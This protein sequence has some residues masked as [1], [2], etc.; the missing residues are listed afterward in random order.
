MFLISHLFGPFIGNT[1]PLAF[2]IVDPHP[3]YPITV[4][5]ISITAFWLYP[6][7]LRFWGH[8]TAL[9]FISIQ[10]LM[11][12]ILW[13]CFFYGGV[14]SPTVPWILTIPLLAFMYLS[15]K[16][17]LRLAVFIMFAANM[18]AFIAA[19]QLGWAT[20]KPDLPVFEM[21]ALGLVSTIAAGLYV[22]MMA[23]VYGKMLASQGELEM[24]MKQHLETAAELR[25]ATI[26]AERAGIAKAEF[27]A[28][29]SHELRTAAER[30]DRLQP[31]AA[32]GR[33]GRR[34]RRDGGRPGAHPHGRAAPAQAHQ[35]GAGPLQDRSRQ[36]GAV[37]AA[38]RSGGAGRGSRAAVP[39]RGAQQADR[40]VAQRRRFDR[41]RRSR[42][43][44]GRAGPVAAHRQRHQV[45]QRRLGPGLA[46]AHLAG[47]RRP[48]HHH[49]RRHRHRHPAGGAAPAVSAVHRGRRLE[50]QQIRRHPALAWRSAANSAA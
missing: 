26:E 19:N 11:F 46:P 9:A 10:N 3:G 15:D 37:P 50:L 48:P 42:R 13:S 33:P 41:L 27:L 39:V 31:D 49:G 20:A 24:E 45:H 16:P 43:D 14:T 35:R 22:T 25:S 47:K 40:A 17:S 36:D 1:V 18:V 30:G 12:C 38:G 5:A 23:I 4:L 6:F 29:M 34:R 8:Y 7:V 21:Q 32:G 28:K 2:Y 44:E